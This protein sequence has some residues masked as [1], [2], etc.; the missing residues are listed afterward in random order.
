MTEWTLCM[1]SKGLLG[2]QS[3]IDAQTVWSGGNEIIT[4]D[5]AGENSTTR[6]QAVPGKTAGDGVLTGKK[7]RRKPEHQGLATGSD[8]PDEHRRRV[9]C[10]HRNKALT[11]VTGFFLYWGI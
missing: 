1:P 3:S 8:V 7:N 11:D 5:R 6:M 2:W 9:I 10:Q 4:A